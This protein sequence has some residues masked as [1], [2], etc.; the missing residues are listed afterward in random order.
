[1]SPLLPQRTKKT[2]VVFSFSLCA[3]HLGASPW[4][5][6]ENDAILNNERKAV[7]TIIKK[8]GRN[9]VSERGSFLRG[10]K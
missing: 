5:K 2:N 9:S 6:A 10:C 3:H 7:N 1:M 4:S 8:R